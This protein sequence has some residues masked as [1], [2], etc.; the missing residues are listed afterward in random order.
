MDDDEVQ[1]DVRTMVGIFEWKHPCES[2]DGRTVVSHQVR[3]R[4]DGALQLYCAG[5]NDGSGWFPPPAGE[6][7]QSARG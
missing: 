1:D 3:V 6:V 4:S 5:C 2:V 7:G